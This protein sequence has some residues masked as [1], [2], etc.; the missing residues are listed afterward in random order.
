MRN[1]QSLHRVTQSLHGALQ[2]LHRARR[3]CTGPHRACTG[4]HRTCIGPRRACIRSHRAC[5]GPRRDCTGPSGATPLHF[6]L[7]SIARL[8]PGHRCGFWMLDPKTDVFLKSAV[9]S[10]CLLHV[11]ISACTLGSHCLLHVLRVSCFYTQRG[12]VS[13]VLISVRDVPMLQVTH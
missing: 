11:S 4:S 5:T 1:L 9:S 10:V 2:S 6:P 7:L 8:I 3:A 12:V 13:F